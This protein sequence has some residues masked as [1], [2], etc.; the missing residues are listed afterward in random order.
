[1]VKL[2]ETDERE[3]LRSRGAVFRALECSVEW[4]TLDFR[5]FR[6]RRSDQSRVKWSVLSHDFKLLIHDF[7]RRISTAKSSQPLINEGITCQTRLP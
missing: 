7:G 3:N 6:L 1:M 4:F 5:G 2:R